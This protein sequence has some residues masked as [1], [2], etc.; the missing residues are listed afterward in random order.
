MKQ[1]ILM[2]LILAM[3]MTASCDQGTYRE[4][5]EIRKQEQYLTELGYENVDTLPGLVEALEDEGQKRLIL[6]YGEHPKYSPE[7]I[8]DSVKT[9]YGVKKGNGEIR[10]VNINAAPLDIEGFKTVKE[11]GIGTYQVFQETYHPEA[12]TWYHQGGKK[13]DYNYRITSLDRAQEAGQMGVFTSGHHGFSPGP[14]SGRSG[15]RGCK[16]PGR[17]LRS[18]R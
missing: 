10:R 6:V 12:Y 2:G 11:A 3:L 15:P 5:E 9:V 13:K 8:A 18:S 1:I 16:R 7:F 4:D 14:L 17:V